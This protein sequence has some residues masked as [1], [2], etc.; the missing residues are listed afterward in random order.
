M[1]SRWKDQGPMDLASNIIFHMI[2]WRKLG[3]RYEKTNN[4]ML[5][6]VWKRGKYTQFATFERGEHD[7]KHASRWTLICSIR[8][9]RVRVSFHETYLCYY[10]YYYWFLV[11][12]PMNRH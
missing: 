8:S 11:V 5:G 7:D 4:L 3:M 10:Y 12:A 1:M 2:S 9:S 6:C